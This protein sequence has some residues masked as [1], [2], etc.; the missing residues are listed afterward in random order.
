MG[1]T[2]GAP[3]WPGEWIKLFKLAR[4]SP[5][6]NNAPSIIVDIDFCGWNCKAPIP[7]IVHSSSTASVELYPWQQIHMWGMGSDSTLQLLASSHPRNTLITS[8]MRSK[9]AWRRHQ[10]LWCTPLQILFTLE[11]FVFHTDFQYTQFHH[12]TGWAQNKPFQCQFCC[13]LPEEW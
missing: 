4:G 11:S 13:L 8:S 12:N 1:C 3:D 2:Q 5:M 10:I 6:W 9:C 7:C